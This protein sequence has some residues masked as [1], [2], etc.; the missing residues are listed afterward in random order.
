MSQFST[1]LLLN[2]HT[3]SPIPETIISNTS[4]LI[5]LSKI[6]E[7]DL[8]SRLYGNIV[9]TPQIADEFGEI[10]PE[11]VKIVPVSDENKFSHNC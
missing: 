11:W 5:I 3:T 4:C 2:Y 6:N 7:L 10:L 8:L 9:T 1:T